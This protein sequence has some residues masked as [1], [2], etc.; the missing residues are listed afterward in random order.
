MGQIQF[1]QSS[2]AAKTSGV[3]V[4]GQYVGYVGE[5]GGH[6]RLRLLPGAHEILIRQAGYEDF[7]RRV[8]IEPGKILDV[9]VG[10]ERDTRFQFPNAK[11]AAMVRLNVNPD[12]AAVFLD[13]NFVG[14]VNEF[15]GAGR[16]MLV[17]PG[18]HSIKI[19]LAGFKTFETDV[20]LLPKQ[21]FV[22]KTALMTGSITDA[23][24]LI[25]PDRTPADRAGTSQAEADDQTK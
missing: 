11:T 12:R 9:Q 10:M 20:T 21:K 1:H 23:D 22:L 5:L 18:K 8:I 16:G 4:D 15:Y 6:N 19:D 2:D 3:W 7:N 13:N 14:H 17:T 25:K 24:V